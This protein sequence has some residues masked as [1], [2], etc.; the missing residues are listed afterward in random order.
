MV[1]KLFDESDDE[2]G[3]TT[4]ISIWGEDTSSEVEEGP[5]SLKIRFNFNPKIAAITL[6]ALIGG[7]ILISILGGSGGGDEKVVATPVATKTAS[8]NVAA[9]IDLYSQPAMLQSFIDNA[10]AST[11]TIFCGQGVGSGWVIDLSDDVSSTQDDAYATE[12]VTNNHV[13]DS[14]GVGSWVTF[15]IMGSSDSYDAYVY[16]TDPINDLTILVTS[17]Y[18]PPMATLSQDYETKVGHWVMAFGSPVGANNEILEGTVTSGNVTNIQD[19]S[20]V[21]DTVIN[22]GNSGGPLVNAAGQVIAINTSKSI[23]ENT[24]NIGYAKKVGL[25][26][27]QLNGCTTKTILK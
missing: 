6:G 11:V 27:V 14:C 12:I 17:K 25:I 26:C 9:N 7:A 2:W 23:R 24:E 8:S 22:P 5:N 15:Y 10:Q 19:E 4:P 18:L 20:I 21:T 13:I 3:Q 16:S 1:R